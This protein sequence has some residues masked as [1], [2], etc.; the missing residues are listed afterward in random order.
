MPAAGRRA[1]HG[2]VRSDDPENAA[3]LPIEEREPE[4]GGLNQI[5]LLDGSDEAEYERAPKCETA[6]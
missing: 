1:V 6:Q 2:G 4:A 5:L 3:K